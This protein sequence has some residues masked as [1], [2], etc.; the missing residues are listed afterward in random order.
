M[1][2]WHFIQTTK[3]W[4]DLVSSDDD[5][6][7]LRK[8]LIDCEELLLHA[9]PAPATYGALVSSIQLCKRLQLD[10]PTSGRKIHPDT[11]PPASSKDVAPQASK[12]FE[13]G[14]EASYRGRLYSSIADL[15]TTCLREMHGASLTMVPGGE[16]WTA[17]WEGVQSVIQAAGHVVD[18][19]ATIKLLRVVVRELRRL[20]TAA[21]AASEEGRK[22][23]GLCGST[24]HLL[25]H[26]AM[27]AGGIE[28][29]ACGQDDPDGL[30]YLRT[31][32][33]AALASHGIRLP[34]EEAMACAQQL[35][36][37]LRSASASAA[38]RRSAGALL[39]SCADQQAV[40][41]LL[42]QQ[43]GDSLLQELTTLVRLRCLPLRQRFAWLRC[44]LLL[45]ALLQQEE[46]VAA[47]AAGQLQEAM[48]ALALLL[49]F[50]CGN[51]AADGV[52]YLDHWSLDAE[53]QGVCKELRALEK[54]LIGA[55]RADARQLVWLADGI[56]S[57]CTRDMV[58]AG[59]RWACVCV[60]A[61]LTAE[62]SVH[63]VCVC[64]PS[65]QTCC[66]AEWLIC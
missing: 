40:L 34:S 9:Q 63:A 43:A 64:A 25:F 35:L 24:Q 47:A 61:Q 58:G 8:H 48:L 32:A 37:T 2:V 33:A 27:P 45:A 50:L 17:A 16:Q 15:V 26:L 20:Q 36:A 41:P 14:D 66:T 19:A 7:A 53:E 4:I 42:V 1:S 29:V 6:H 5:V 44:G 28:E 49:G 13:W 56:R 21:L 22:A 62:L 3:Y 10:I 11:S 55:A 46:L 57:M 39:Q 18:N 60:C 52:E 65:T 12:R 38:T 59:L 51:K 54:L 23:A 31:I 30:P